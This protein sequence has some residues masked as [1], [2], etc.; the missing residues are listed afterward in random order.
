MDY[1]IYNQMEDGSFRQ[2]AGETEQAYME[3][4]IRAVVEARRNKEIES[5]NDMFAPEFCG[6]SAEDG[7]LR[8]RYRPQSWQKNPNGVLHGGI[9]TATIDM[10][11]GMLTRYYVRSSKS[12]TVQLNVSFMREIPLEHSY[13]V[14]AKADKTGRR[15]KFLSAEITDELTGKIAAKAT[16]MFM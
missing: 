14:L 3:R 4:V 11:L 1:G 8:L 13:Y 9:I 12:L 10:T 15:V 16:S 2:Q 6:C 5:F 7:S